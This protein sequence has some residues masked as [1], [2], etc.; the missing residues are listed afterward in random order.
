M[1][2]TL[3]SIIIYVLLGLALY[4]LG[5]K[6]KK[7]TIRALYERISLLEKE[8]DASHQSEI[9]AYMALR[10]YK[11]NNPPRN[12]AFVISPEMFNEI[13]Y[14]LYSFGSDAP[15]KKRDLTPCRY[16]RRYDS[17]VENFTDKIRN[18]GLTGHYHPFC[19]SEVIRQAT[20]ELHRRMA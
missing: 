13:K 10:E 12:S 2:N 9:K 6:E 11:C 4:N 19:A 16:C 15:S 1:I 7:Y 8:A 5:K 20:A 17:K 3:I 14:K 18:D